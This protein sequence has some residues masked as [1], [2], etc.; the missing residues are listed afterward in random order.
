[1]HNAHK[2]D[3]AVKLIK[4]THAEVQ[5]MLNTGEGQLAGGSTGLMLEF[6]EMEQGTTRHRSCA[7]M[8]AQ[9]S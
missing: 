5:R 1:M 9:L 2:W 6:T 7:V 4:S 8:Y 3:A